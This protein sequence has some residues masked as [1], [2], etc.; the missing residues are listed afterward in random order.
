MQPTTE[1][2][3]IL[4]RATQTK[5]NL[6]LYARAGA[7][8]TT[9]LVLLAEALKDV[10]ILAIAFNTKIAKE[11]TERLPP[12]CESRT[13]N[14]LG[15]E[16]WRRFRDKHHKIDDKKLFELLSGAIKQRPQEEQAD[17]FE[18]FADLLRVCKEAKVYGYV[19]PKSNSMIVGIIDRAD[20]YGQNE[21]VTSEDEQSL[22]DHVLRTS[23][24]MAFEGLIDFSDQIYLT[25]LC[26]SVSFPR[27]EAVFVDEAQDLSELNHILLGKIAKGARVIAVG[28]PCQAIYGF[29]GAEEDSM[30]LLSSRFNLQPMYLTVCFRS[31]EEIVRNAHW[32]A[33]DMQWWPTTPHGLVETLDKWSF[34]DLKPG[35]A[36]IC[37][38]NAPLF[39]LA[40]AMLSSGLRPELLSGDIV[41]GLIKTM[42][43]FGKRE[44]KR[45]SAQL[46]LAEWVESESKRNRSHAAIRDKAD[47]IGIFINKGE[48]LG[49]AIDLLQAIADMT[50]SIKLMTGHKSKGL[51]FERVWFLDRDLCRPKGQDLN[52]RYVIETRA[53]RE[54]RYITTDGL[55]K[56]G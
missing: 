31:S 15:N 47:C 29:R 16:A 32:R 6:A 53:K 48:T 25:A 42:K 35:D 39:Y 4:E 21:I 1:Q 18:H 43:S 9:T 55:Q 20:F 5:D 7:A 24:A 37:R 44:L 8:K 30:T 17:L 38:N 45:E 3:A 2:L 19:P 28:D 40:V 34:D 50:G 12:W 51:E 52:L 11:M 23:I 54:L 10:D 49:E 56:G 46:A 13:I 14:S 36:I 27:R 22:I 33:P 41:P 26:R